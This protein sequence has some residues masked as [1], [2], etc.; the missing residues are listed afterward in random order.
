M[1]SGV[2]GRVYLVGAGPGDAGLI[3]VRGRALLEKADVVI[4]DYL[5]NESLLKVVRPDAEKIYVGKKAG[6]H[7]MPQSEINRLLVE[8]GRHKVVVRL[9]GGDPFVFGRGGEEAQELAAAGIP[10]EVVP[11]VT[12][13]IAV[14]AYAGIP[15]SHRDFASTITFITGHEREDQQDS[16]INWKA[17]AELGGTLVFF[18]GVKNI[19]IIASRLMENGLA[20]NTPVAVIRWGTTPHQK[21]VCGV[22]EDIEARVAAEG[23]TPPAIIVVGEVVKLRDELSWF[24]KKPLFGKTIV[25]TRARAQASRLSEGLRELGAECI[26]FPTIAFEPP[27]SWDEADKAIDGLERYDWIVFTSANGVE[28][29]FTRLWE[30]G[31]DVRS[32]WKASIAAIGPETAKAVEK[33]G[34]RVDLIPASYRAEDL[35][36]AFPGET[37]LGKEI[38]IPRALEAREV[39]PQI[40]ENRGAKVTVVPVYRT[41]MPSGDMAEK[42]ARD[43]E[44]GRIDC[45]T[46]TSSSTVRNFLSL[47]KPVLSPD[48]LLKVVVACIGPVTAQT[49]E[50]LGLS[51]QVVADSYTI[52]G[53]IDALVR[54][55]QFK[56]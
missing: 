18:M 34:I 20:P 47:M 5:V 23:I 31:K 14:P 8:K 13:A 12:A 4:Y 45:I 54:Y 48:S 53:L 55:F 42:L 26:E 21:T 1:S 35:A 15:V 49:A 44:N 7:T 38:L 37:V 46:F 39:L 16:R 41:V 30:R 33:K 29:F 19:G 51:V 36:E 10:Y 24:E 43:I 11:G 56:L 6:S 32:L 50:E 22:L 3:S 40:L 27:P 17:L 28:A 9:K 25:V 2:K 52:D